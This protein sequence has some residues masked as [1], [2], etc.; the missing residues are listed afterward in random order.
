[1]LILHSQWNPPD[2]ASACTGRAQRSTKQIK[3]LVPYVLPN[4]KL[5]LVLKYFSPNRSSCGSDHPELVRPLVCEG[6]TEK[7]VYISAIPLS[8][9]SR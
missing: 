7:K 8:Q 3:R 1:M 6:N 9:A 5:G 2:V 4:Q